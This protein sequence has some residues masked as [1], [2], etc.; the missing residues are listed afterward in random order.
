[1]ILTSLVHRPEQ[2]QERWVGVSIKRRGAGRRPGDRNRAR[3]LRGPGAGGSWRRAHAIAIGWVAGG[4]PGRRSAR[5]TGV[6][7]AVLDGPRR[8]GFGLVAGCGCRLSRL[9][10]R[11]AFLNQCARELDR[12]FQDTLTRS[13]AQ[14]DLVSEEGEIGAHTCSGSANLVNKKSQWAASGAGRGGGRIACD[15]MRPPVAG[16]GKPNVPGKLVRVVGSIVRHPALV[17]LL[18]NSCLETRPSTMSCCVS[19]CRAI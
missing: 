19:R 10:G 2:G 12:Q 5:A 1:M 17:F 16:R 7:I 14:D 8:R 11:A 9:R 13:T 3:L 6:R 15:E 4:P 18:W